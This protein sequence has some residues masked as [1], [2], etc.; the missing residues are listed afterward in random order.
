MRIEEKLLTDNKFDEVLDLTK[1]KTDVESIY[2]RLIALIA[3]SNIKEASSLIESNRDALFEYKPAS[4]IK[5]DIELSLAELEF[6]DARNKLDVYETYPYVSQEVEECL[7]EYKSKIEK[8]EREILSSYKKKI[9][10]SSDGG[11]PSLDS[12]NETIYFYL[13][14]ISSQKNI[15]NKD[16][17]FCLSITSSNKDISLRKLA[18]MILT[19]FKVNTDIEFDGIRT[20]PSYLTLPNMDGKY[21]IVKEKLALLPDISLSSISTSILNSYSYYLFPNYIND[22]EKTY[23]QVVSLG[24]KYLGLDIDENEEKL[25]SDLEKMIPNQK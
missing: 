11:V 1:D 9:N 2:F 21:K 10:E 17:D 13:S 7:R 3:K 16:K 23:L 6:A 15:E 22:Y 8:E 19:L 24:K 5:M 4:L 14:S 20:N 18:L 12:P 25:A